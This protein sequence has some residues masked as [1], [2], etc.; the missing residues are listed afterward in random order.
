[1]A[2]VSL[3][4]RIVWVAPLLVLGSDRVARRMRVLAV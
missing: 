1:M 2:N 4:T 3:P